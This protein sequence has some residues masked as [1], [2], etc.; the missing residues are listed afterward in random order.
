MIVEGQVEN[1]SQSSMKNVV[2]VANFYTQDG[3]FITSENALIEYDPIPPGQ[4]SPFK[5][6]A[7]YNPAMKRCSVDFKEF[8]GGK[9]NFEDGRT[10]KNSNSFANV[11]RIREAQKLLNQLGYDAGPV[12]GQMGPKTSAAMQQF[13]A[14]NGFQAPTVVTV[15][16][17]QQLQR[18]ASQ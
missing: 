4:T 13:A 16:F 6:G 10:R 8:F 11:V 15:E 9:I 3:E 18:A 2:A 14:A 17:L 1:I 12:D 7:R 5:T